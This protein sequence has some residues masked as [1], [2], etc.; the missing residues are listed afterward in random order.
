VFA[1]LEKLQFEQ[2]TTEIRLLQSLVQSNNG[3]NFSSTFYDVIF[4]YESF[5]GVDFLLKIALLLNL[6]FE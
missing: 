2:N 4:K 1:I 6:K 3:I 5:Y